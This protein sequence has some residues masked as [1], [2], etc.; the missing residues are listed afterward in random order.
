[1]AVFAVDASV[2]LAWYFPDEQTDRTDELLERLTQG[3]RVI[4]PAH[5]PTDAFALC[6]AP[7]CL[8]NETQ[9]PLK[10]GQ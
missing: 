10:E 3:D 9:T 2:T 6:T 5:W 7:R 4:V 1:M 8:Q